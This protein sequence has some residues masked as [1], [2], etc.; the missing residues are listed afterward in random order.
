MYDPIADT[1]T[2]VG[3]L[4]TKRAGHS[5]SLLPNGNVLVAGG[6]TDLSDVLA[7][8]T[9]ALKTTEIYDPATQLFTA[10]PNLARPHT[11]LLCHGPERRGLWTLQ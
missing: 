8:A 7:G 10:G 4:G 2:T 1:W 5:A 3:P 11:V 9:S 6:S